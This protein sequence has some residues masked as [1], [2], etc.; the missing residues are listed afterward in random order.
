MTS[1]N[2]IHELLE[3]GGIDWRRPIASYVERFGVTRCPWL[4]IDIVLVGDSA[5]LV[6]GLLRPLEFH[7]R[8]QW[9]IDQP[10][11]HFFGLVSVADDWFANFQAALNAL[12][13]RLG[14]PETDDNANSR[15]RRWRDGEAEITIRA[16]LPELQYPSI[17]LMHEREPRTRTACHVTI[18]TGYRPECTA[19]ERALLAGFDPLVDLPDPPGR[20]SEG[21]SQYDL[22]YVRTLPGDLRHLSGRIGRAGDR[23]AWARTDLHLV[24][25]DDVRNVTVVRCRPARGPGQ[26]AVELV[27]ASPAA[28]GLEK[29]LALGI[30]RHADGLDGWAAALAERLER[31]LAIQ[32]TY[33]D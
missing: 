33:D 3:R 6:P 27:C 32:E 2:R 21:P 29:S 15:G 25:L 14:R 7:L 19:T 8:P 17:N 22:E 23:L 28:G 1:G 18:A 16:W 24:P 5:N 20:V 26:G 31:P 4:D 12:A 30:H 11:L 13:D 9:A 10:P